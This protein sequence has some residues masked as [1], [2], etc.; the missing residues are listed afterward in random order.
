MVLGSATPV[1]ASRRD[2]DV[3]G[4]RVHPGP[5]ENT[6]CGPSAK[7][8]GDAGVCKHPGLFST[9]A[10]ACGI[11]PADWAT[12]A[13]HKGVGT[14]RKAVILGTAIL[15]FTLALGCMSFSFGERTEVIR[16]PEPSAVADAAE[17]RGKVAV[18]GGEEITVYYPVPYASP[19]NLV[20]RDPGGVCRVVEQKA[21]C[22]RIVNSASLTM[23]PYDV[24]WTA[25]GVHASP[26]QP[27]PA[28]PPGTSPALAN[29]VAQ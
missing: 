16:S 12:H 7:G 2:L 17:Q 20:I 6:A 8:E 10:C 4:G 14:V 13:A 18:P 1:G 22:F 24:V 15:S 9:A 25:R 27:N 28:V 19:P 23:G 11:S 29:P 21:D 3:T 5:R 26:A